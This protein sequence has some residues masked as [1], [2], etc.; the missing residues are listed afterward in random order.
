[1]IPHEQLRLANTT[2]KRQQIEIPHEYH[3]QAQPRIIRN[4][5]KYI[6]V[7]CAIVALIL[8]SNCYCKLSPTKAKAVTIIKPQS[9]SHKGVAHTQ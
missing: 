8:I 5:S 7:S 4:P 3:Y 2:K 1:M 9:L 6:K